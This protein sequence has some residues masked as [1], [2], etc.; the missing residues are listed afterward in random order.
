MGAALELLAPYGI[1]VIGIAARGAREARAVA[2]ETGFP[3]AVK[4]ADL[5]GLYKSDRG[6]VRVGLA[7]G[8]A[9]E[10]AV[11]EFGIELGTAEPEV[12]VQPVVGGVEVSVSVVPD[13][14]F[15]PLVRISAGGIA[16]RLLGDDVHL[17][18]PVS[19]S[20]V[21]RALRGLRIWPLLDGFRGSPRVD[22]E[23]LETLALAVAQLAQDV[24]QIERLHLNPVFARPDGLSCVDV[25]VLLQPAEAPDAGVPRR[26]RP[27]S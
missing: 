17:L 16:S 9:V 1:D 4:V 19:R 14:T 5:E 7:S 22:L 8:A 27:L 11:Q 24:P 13:E 6:L 3:V 23:A 15:G 20:D 18:P 12:R 26:L 2:E 21:A 25:K 10:A